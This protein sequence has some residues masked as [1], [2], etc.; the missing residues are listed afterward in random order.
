MSTCHKV[1]GLHISKYIMRENYRTSAKESNMHVDLQCCYGDL[2][3]HSQSA[4]DTV[5]S[6]ACMQGFLNNAV[7]I[8]MKGD[9]LNKPSKGFRYW[10]LAYMTHTN[11]TLL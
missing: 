10:L 3:A 11:T 7:L 4:S 1:L 6:S 2:Y 8:L 9:K 5:M